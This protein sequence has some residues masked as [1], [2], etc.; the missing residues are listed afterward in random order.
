M[1]CK[2][3]CMACEFG[4]IR[5]VENNLI[6]IKGGKIEAQIECLRGWENVRKNGN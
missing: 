6:G 4:V 1:K 5:N 2:E 3:N